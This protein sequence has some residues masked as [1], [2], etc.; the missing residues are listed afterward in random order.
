MTYYLELS[1][2]GSRVVDP[3]DARGH[4]VGHG[5]VQ[6]VVAPGDA[7][8]HHTGHA[9]DEEEDAQNVGDHPSSGKICRERER[10]KEKPIKTH[11]TC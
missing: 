2:H 5:H 9:T 1:I 7:Q 11:P 10:E 6:G 3:E 8:A 4:E